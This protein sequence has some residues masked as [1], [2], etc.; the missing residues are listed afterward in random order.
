[1]LRTLVS[2]TT[3]IINF[4]KLKMNYI[5]IFNCE[6]NPQLVK[7]ISIISRIIEKKI[8]FGEIYYS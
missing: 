8:F 4:Y 7:M 5:K 2:S 1:M 6:Y 3:I